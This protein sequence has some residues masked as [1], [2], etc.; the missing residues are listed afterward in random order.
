MHG[1]VY[2]TLPC[3]I[4]STAEF[5]QEIALRVKGMLLIL[6]K[7]L[8]KVVKSNLL[9]VLPIPPKTHDPQLFGLLHA[10]KR[11]LIV[12]QCH[13]RVTQTKAGTQELFTHVCTQGLTEAQRI[14]TSED[15]RGQVAQSF[16]PQHSA[17]NRP[18]PSR[19]PTVRHSSSP[20][21]R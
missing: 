14:S 12:S 18:P 20:P 19:S 8:L 11:D 4:I 16:L 1:A 13:T 2:K 15:R 21:V 17:Q 3:Y 5:C 9:K 7:S 6:F 10:L